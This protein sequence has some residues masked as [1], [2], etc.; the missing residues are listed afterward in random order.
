MVHE[1]VEI[2]IIS[3]DCGTHFATELVKKLLVMQSVSKD[4]EAELVGVAVDAAIES[5]SASGRAKAQKSPQACIWR[6]IA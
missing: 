3:V 6:Q 5:V 1:V 2:D 4:P